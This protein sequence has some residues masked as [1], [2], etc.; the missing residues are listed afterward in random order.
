MVKP[1]NLAIQAG[2]VL[3][4][5]AALLGVY[6]LDRSD[7]PFSRAAT[8]GAEQVTQGPKSTGPPATIP[9]KD[10]EASTPPAPAPVPETAGKERTPA[11]KPPAPDPTP[12]EAPEQPKLHIKVIETVTTKTV[13]PRP[14]RLAV[15]P[16]TFDDMGRLLTSLGEGY[17][18][19]LIE[20][21]EVRDPERLAQF[22]VLF[23]TCAAGGLDLRK[24]LRDF[25]ARGGTLYAS[26]WRLEAVAVAFPEFVSLF[27][28][29]VGVKQDVTADVLDPGLR[30]L[31]GPQVVIRFDLGS[32]KAAAFGGQGVNTLLRGKYQKLFGSGLGDASLL[33]KFRHGEGTVIFTSFHNEKQNSNTELKLLRYL[34]FTAVTAQAES[35]LTKTIISGGL[36]PHLLRRGAASADDPQVSHTYVHKKAGRLQFALAF[37]NQGARL[38]LTLVAPDGREI[39]REGAAGFIVEVQDAPAGTWRYTVT[40]PILPFP[41]FPFTLTVGEAAAP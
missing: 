9:A 16:S 4:L 25:V 40:A 41:N 8:P 27:K 24:S 26:D 38:R 18:Y 33:V 30:E 7:G 28:I 20:T 5:G 35:R 22:D 11:V 3:A 13:K 36:S 14:L 2:A 15:T 34:V 37:E 29:G 6:A 12:P 39:K 19:T 1:Q 17:K 31:V 10:Q 32:W 21:A 23:L